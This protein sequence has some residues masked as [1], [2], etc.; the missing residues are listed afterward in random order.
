ME[1]KSYKVSNIANTNYKC[2]K[3]RVNSHNY[4]PESV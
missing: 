4:V 1:K 2:T 3:L